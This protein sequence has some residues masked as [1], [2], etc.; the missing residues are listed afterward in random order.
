M[1]LFLKRLGKDFFHHVAD[2]KKE[3]EDNR[4]FVLLN[5][6]TEDFENKLNL[7]I[8]QFQDLLS[9]KGPVLWKMNVLTELRR[10][11]WFKGLLG[12]YPLVILATSNSHGISQ[13]TS[14]Y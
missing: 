2:T 4:M 6:H 8:P 11:E 14:D 13:G 9:D 10:K 5:A 7:Q 3:E 12:C 1:R